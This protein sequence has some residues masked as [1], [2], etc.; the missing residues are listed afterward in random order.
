MNIISYSNYRIAG[1]FGKRKLWRIY[2]NTILAREKFGE[3]VYVNRFV[4]DENI[5][6]I[7][8]LAKRRSF[9]SFAKFSFRQTF[10][11]YSII[12]R[13]FKEVYTDVA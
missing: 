11:L 2:C 10:V 13:N 1:N 3:F 12:I 9:V 6:W 7:F 5:W 4:L 8:S